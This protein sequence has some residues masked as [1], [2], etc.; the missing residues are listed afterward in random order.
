MTMHHRYALNSDYRDNYRCW[1]RPEPRVRVCSVGGKYALRQNSRLCICGWIG[2][3]SF[4]APRQVLN[5]FVKTNGKNNGNQKSA[6]ENLPML[7]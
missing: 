4:K 5:G 6:H 7:D 1:V 2:L 3:V